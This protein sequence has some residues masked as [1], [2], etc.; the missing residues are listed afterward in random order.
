[1]VPLMDLHIFF[2]ITAGET[3]A[4]VDILSIEIEIHC[5]AQ[6]APQKE[7]LRRRKPTIYTS[8]EQSETK[9]SLGPASYGL[10]A[11]LPQ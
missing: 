7:A 3:L 4:V 5:T 6:R 2:K 9:S 8:R 10:A 1:M 11:E